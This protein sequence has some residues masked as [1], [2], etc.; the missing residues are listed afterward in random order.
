MS[1]IIYKITNQVTNKSYIGQTQQSLEIRWKQHIKDSNK[2]N[3]KFSRSIRKYGSECW[4]IEILESN[5]DP[6]FLNEREVYWIS[7]FDTFKNGYNSTT[8]GTQRICFSEESLIKMSVAKRGTF[9]SEETKKKIGEASKG[10]IGYFKNKPR[11]EETKEKIR[12]TNLGKKASEE[13]KRK[14]S[15]SQKRRQLKNQEVSSF[16]LTS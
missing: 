15:E 12:Q 1:S 8:G 2:S 7:H 11:S 6:F 5:L 3:F 9:H 16:S 10:R 14:M 13:T 4:K